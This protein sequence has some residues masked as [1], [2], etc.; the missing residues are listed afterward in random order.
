[1]LRETRTSNLLIRTFVSVPLL[2]NEIPLWSS[3]ANVCFK[4]W[5]QRRLDSYS[6]IRAKG[7][8]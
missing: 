6:G 4:R 7:N 5:L 3:K 1:M 2:R 8:T